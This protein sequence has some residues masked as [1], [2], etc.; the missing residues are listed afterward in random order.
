[1]YGYLSN[2]LKHLTTKEYNALKELCMYSNNL[3]NNIIRV[4]QDYKKSN[5]RIPTRKELYY[6]MKTDRNYKILNNHNAQYVLKIVY[7]AY[8]GFFS[9]LKNNDD[10]HK[11]INEPSFRDDNDLF[12]LKMPVDVVFNEYNSTYT[13]PMSQ[14]YR[15]LHDRMKIKVLVP[16]NL[17]GKRV[18]EISIIPCLN[19]FYI[20]Y[21][22]IKD[23]TSITT[24]SDNTLAIDL[25]IDNLATCV[26]NNGNSFIIDGKGLKY[27]IYQW[28]KQ[29]KN[30]QKIYSRQG[31]FETKELDK[32]YLKRSNSIKDYMHKSARI[33]IDYCIQ[34]NIRNIVVGWSKGFKDGKSL[35]KSTK[36]SFTNIP[37]TVLRRQL[38]Y[39]CDCY[40]LNYMEHKESYTSQAS[41]LD[42]DMMPTFPQK[43]AKPFSG[44]RITRGQY[45][46]SD[47][48]VINADV[49][50]AANILVKSGL[51]YDFDT[52]KAGILHLAPHK[53]KIQ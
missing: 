30:L 23:K 4:I 27:I 36:N 10:P 2:R 14:V 24:D 3:Y 29:R 9:R 47:G 12:V 38:Q 20:H 13:I 32:I 28:M 25:G 43:P 52:M 15:L 49:N 26:D 22:Y 33:I 48:T 8:S 11:Q 46:S 51:P 40:G 35:A 7:R 16:E 6:L 37:Y 42:E 17:Y 31:I 53:I 34:N 45:Q 1:M 18:K 41:F 19:E 50:G 5:N 21:V 39:L 44:K